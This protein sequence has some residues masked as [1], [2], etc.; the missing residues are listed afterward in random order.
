[1]GSKKMKG[2]EDLVFVGDRCNT[3]KEGHMRYLPE[4]VLNDGT[5]VNTA[6]CNHC[7]NI[8]ELTWEPFRSTRYTGVS[9][10][11]KCLYEYYY[12]SIADM[13]DFLEE[14]EQ[15]CICPNCGVSGY[16]EKITEKYGVLKHKHGEL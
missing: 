8:E 9:R 16:Q 12:V 14:I 4:E 11:E 2:K 5:V 7:G 1:M 3:C 15:F 10:C 6:R 13:D